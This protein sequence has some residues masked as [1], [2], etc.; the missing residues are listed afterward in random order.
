MNSCDRE[1]LTAAADA[2]RRALPMPAGELAGA[3][4][5]LMRTI[6]ARDLAGMP[7][8]VVPTSTLPADI[9]CSY[10]Q[11]CTFPGL[12]WMVKPHLSHR[13][14]GPGPA[15]LIDDRAIQKD[16]GDGAV[17]GFLGTVLHE[18]AHAI[19]E[20][21]RIPATDPWDDTAKKEFYEYAPQAYQENL[22]RV[23][24][25]QKEGHCQAAARHY[26]AHSP[27]EFLRV[28]LHLRHRAELAGICVPCSRLVEL[29]DC[30]P[31]NSYN[32]LLADELREMKDCTIAEILAAPLPAEYLKDAG[33]DRERFMRELA[34]VAADQRRKG[35]DETCSASSAS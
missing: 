23:F 27:E 20:I 24:N 29:W 21:Q 5:A 32:Y 19:P 30:Y 6:A 4:E 12:A 31:L 22:Q 3:A 25:V 35:D 16:Y 7:V 15:A 33:A 13:W 17:T 10:I 14:A 18:M 11:G 8:Y 26:E 1:L 9:L 28:C 34:N 2:M